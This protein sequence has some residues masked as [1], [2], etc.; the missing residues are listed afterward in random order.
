MMVTRGGRYSALTPPPSRAWAMYALVCMSCI[1][2]RHI[3]FHKEIN[4]RM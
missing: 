1:D 4:Y 2:N 3:S